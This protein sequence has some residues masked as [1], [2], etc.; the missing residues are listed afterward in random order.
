[1]QI[2]GLIGKKLSH[3]FSRKHF[4][5]KF[6]REQ[7]LA[8]YRLFELA[9]ISEFP[10]LIQQHPQ[11]IGL[12]VTIPYKEAVIPYL[13]EVDEAAAE[14]GAVNTIRVGA[15]KLKGFNTDVI[16]F[17]LPLEKIKQSWQAA[18]ILG[19]GGAAKAVH[20][21]LQHQFH[22]PEIL[23]VSRNPSHQNQLSYTQLH[24]LDLAGF[25]IIINTT[26][27]GMYPNVASAP[28]FPYHQLSPQHIAYDLIYNPAETAFMKR[29][30]AQGARVLNGMEML[31]GQAEAAWNIWN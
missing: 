15:G 27:L 25:S 2:Y 13:D 28:D 29:A 19:T 30:K 11:L 5:D 3:S 17:G 7:L 18:I 26:P 14:I 1:M 22:I 21:A 20:Y 24:Q 8:D 6:A 4:Q 23:F 31:I 9:K 10:A 12:N 16:G